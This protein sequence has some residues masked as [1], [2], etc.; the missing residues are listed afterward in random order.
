MAKIQPS[1]RSFSAG[2]VFLPGGS[3]TFGNAGIIPDPDNPATLKAVYLDEAQTQIA[4]N[5]QPLDSNASF[6]QA[7]DGILYGSGTYSVI[8]RNAAGVEVYQNLNFELLEDFGTAAFVN[9]G[10]ASNE[11]PLNSDLPDFGTAAEANTGTA[12]GNLPTADQ[13]NMVGVS[14]TNW[15]SNNLLN[16]AVE[17]QAETGGNN[18]TLPAGG[19]Y[20]YW[21]FTTNAS[22]NVDGNNING[23]AAGGTVIT[24]NSSIIRVWYKKVAS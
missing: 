7:S 20:D 23:R 11:V 6:R 22:G 9:T 3:I 4:Q 16:Q 10:T 1:T 13:L 12:T 18:V 2:S 19:T 24:N 21:G 17:S 8:W 14:V 5:P 15:T